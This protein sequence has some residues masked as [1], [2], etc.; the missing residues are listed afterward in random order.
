MMLLESCACSFNSFIIFSEITSEEFKQKTELE[1]LEGNIYKSI[2]SE[3]I[4]DSVQEEIKKEFPKESIHRRNTGYAVDEFCHIYVWR[5]SI[6]HKCGKI[7][8][9]K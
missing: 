8:S 4:Y 5:D 3:L 9:R 6:K 1:S 7:I 2:Y